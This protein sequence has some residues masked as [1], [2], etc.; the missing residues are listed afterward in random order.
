MAR[1]FQSLNVGDTFYKTPTSK[2]KW[3]KYSQEKALCGKTGEFKT[4][5]LDWDTPYVYSVN[6]TK[7]TKTETEGTKQMTDTLYQIKGTEDYG[8]YLT[9][10]R[11]GNFVLEMKGGGGVK[12]FPE[13]QLEEVL[14]YTVSIQYLGNGSDS[15][16][17]AYLSKEGEFS[18]GDFLFG[19]RYGGF[20]KVT[21]VDTK[22]KH[23][24]KRFN[25][26]KLQ[27]EQIKGDN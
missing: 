4:Y 19:G 8:I 2:K 5:W 7:E 17:Y 26:W 14:P 25:G 15:K 3:V 9:K 23:A 6:E 20:A 27:A 24:T 12:A 18:V 13:D 16:S 1:C 21:A 10:D 22:S 11:S